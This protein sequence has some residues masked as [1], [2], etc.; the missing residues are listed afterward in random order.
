MDKEVQNVLQEVAKL[1]TNGNGSVT[2]KEVEEFVDK[3]LRKECKK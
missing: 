1:D 3:E 2:M